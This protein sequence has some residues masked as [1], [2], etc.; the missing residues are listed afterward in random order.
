[1]FQH[2][3][4]IVDA[5]VFIHDQV[6]SVNPSTLTTRVNF[7][8]ICKLCVLFRLHQISY[9]LFLGNVSPNIQEQSGTPLVCY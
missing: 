3:C 2:F 5:D 7:R 8:Y 6:Y 4:E 1:M 9:D